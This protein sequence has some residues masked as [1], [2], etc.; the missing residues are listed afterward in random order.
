[1]IEMHQREPV[2]H[3]SSDRCHSEARAYGLQTDRERPRLREPSSRRQTCSCSSTARSSSS[4]AGGSSSAED[5][6]LALALPD[7]P[8]L[9]SWERRCGFHEWV[10]SAGHERTMSA[11]PA[12]LHTPVSMSCR[13]ISCWPTPESSILRTSHAL[14]EV[15][16]L[17][18]CS[19]SGWSC[20]GG[21]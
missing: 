11:A 8:M 17:T 9:R 5:D 14:G 12:L 16:E 18:F 6:R 13:M 4:P 10:W 21:R 20:G 3:E 7:V 1:M 2:A 15:C 19:P